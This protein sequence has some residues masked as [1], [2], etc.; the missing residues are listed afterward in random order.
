MRQVIWKEELKQTAASCRVS[1]FRLFN[2]IK[3]TWVLRH[4]TVMKTAL[5]LIYILIVDVFMDPI[6]Y[7]LPKLS[8]CLLKQFSCLGN[9]FKYWSSMTNLRHRGLFLYFPITETI[10]TMKCIYSLVT[11]KQGRGAFYLLPHVWELLVK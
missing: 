11:E 10:H 4:K 6:S 2:L 9:A 5:S 3:E 8:L 1:C 7:C